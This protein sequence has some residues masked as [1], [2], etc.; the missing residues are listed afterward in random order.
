[1]DGAGELVPSFARTSHC[2]NAWGARSRDACDKL[3]LTKPTSKL[4][5]KLKSMIKQRERERERRGGG[6][7]DLN[8]PSLYSFR[9]SEWWGLF[10]CDELK[11][12]KREPEARTDSFPM[13]GARAI[14]ERAHAG[15]F[16]AE[17]PFERK[18]F[19][20]EL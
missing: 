18:A 13:L 5:L 8:W 15:A 17:P 19:E 1:M 9:R 14:K 2:P 20:L 10:C 11:T 4:K 6:G 7:K 3:N 12:R 16:F